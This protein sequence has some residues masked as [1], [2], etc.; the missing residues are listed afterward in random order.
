MNTYSSSSALG[1]DHCR[2]HL[3]Q[4]QPGDDLVYTGYPTEL[5]THAYPRMTSVRMI[6]PCPS[7][8]FGHTWKVPTG[9]NIFEMMIQYPTKPHKV[10]T[11]FWVECRRMYPSYFPMAGELGGLE[12]LELL[13]ILAFMTRL[14]GRW[15]TLVKSFQACL[16]R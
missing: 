6:E 10:S 11:D 16:I 4:G 8:D 2:G 5:I 12:E 9:F 15:R 1:H 13:E 14:D 3:F 7:S